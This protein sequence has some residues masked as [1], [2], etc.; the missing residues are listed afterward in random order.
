VIVPAFL[1]RIL[2]V[3]VDLL[4]KH[5]YYRAA[6]YKPNTENDMRVFDKIQQKSA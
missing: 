6:E 1:Y 3:D 5:A 2:V 4:F